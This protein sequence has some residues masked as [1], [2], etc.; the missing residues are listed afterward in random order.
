MIQQ[1]LVNEIS[2]NFPELLIIGKSVKIRFKTWGYRAISSA[3]EVKRSKILQK[4]NK[5]DCYRLHSFF[6]FYGV[7]YENKYMIYLCV[8]LIF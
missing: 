1:K 3:L 4:L 6:H 8:W 7:S 2:L 5:G